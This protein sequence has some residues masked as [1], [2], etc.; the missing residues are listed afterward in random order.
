V[1]QLTSDALLEVAPDN[2]VI[3]LETRVGAFIP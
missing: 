1:Q 2:C 3:R